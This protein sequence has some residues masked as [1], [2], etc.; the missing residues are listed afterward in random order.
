MDDL[1]DPDKPAHATARERLDSDLIAWLITTTRDGRPHPAPV[2]FFRHD[3]VI[4]ILSEPDTI[5][6]THLRRGSAAVLHLDSG[7]P[8]GDDICV[9]HG[10]TRLIEGGAS[11]W[12][13]EFGERY[14]AKYDAAIESY[15]MPLEK[16]GETFSTRIE[17]T[18]TK[19]IAWGG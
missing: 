19:V 14:R 17:F 7:G 9:L 8:F 4:T 1:F 2:W 15:G 13:D 11:A 3:D 16:F 18:P 6:V 5:K 12:L 10:T